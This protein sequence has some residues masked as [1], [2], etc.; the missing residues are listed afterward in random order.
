MIARPHV[1]LTCQ[2]RLLKHSAAPKFHFA[3]LSTRAVPHLIP[4]ESPKETTFD[5]PKEQNEKTYAPHADIPPLT[6]VTIEDGN[7]ITF[8]LAGKSKFIAEKRLNQAQR[9][10]LSEHPLGK[11]F[12]YTGSMQREGRETLDIESLGKAAEV[13]VLRDSGLKFTR[14]TTVIP[15]AE[16][17]EAVD[18]LATLNKERGIVAHTQVDENISTFRPKKGA[19]L[20][21]RQQFN[22]LVQQ[23]QSSFTIS[24][25]AKY[26]Q[27]FSEGKNSN[28]TSLRK[29]SKTNLIRRITPF[30]PQAAIDGDPNDPV[31]IRG[32]SYPSY[33]TKQRL[34]LRVM[35]ECWMLQLPELEDGIGE[36]EVEL[37]PPDFELL[38][39]TMAKLSD[40]RANIVLSEQGI[41]IS[42]FTVYHGRNLRQAY[43][44]S[45]GADRNIHR[46][47]HFPHCSCS[48]QV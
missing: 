46:Q 17:A 41:R 33:T 38:S 20:Q 28:A 16:K 34:A 1:C 19:E 30:L 4:D 18:I 21:D 23:I 3:Y 40:I 24:Q 25:L 2:L 32:Y 10:G 43:C 12:G 15:E 44:E 11:L 31:S 7:G 37:T 26:I 42:N 6:A 27:T 5:E 13:I 35:R 29:G 14:K 22:E 47:L 8:P 45:R 39:K 9:V 48:G 36:I